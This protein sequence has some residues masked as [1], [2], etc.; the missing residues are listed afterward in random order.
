MHISQLNQDDRIMFHTGAGVLLGTV[1]KFTLAKNGLN[2][3]C[4]WLDL[5]DVK[6]EG[7]I[8][9]KSEIRLPGSG[10]AMFKISKV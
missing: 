9:Y 10:L 7:G 1:D 4:S 5:R 3:M 2:K 8:A 6:T